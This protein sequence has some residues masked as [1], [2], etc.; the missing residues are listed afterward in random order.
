[1]LNQSSLA[2]V[3][4]FLILEP[5]PLVCF[6]LCPCAGAAFLSSPTRARHTQTL[7]APNTPPQHFV[8]LRQPSQLQQATWSLQ[9]L[10]IMMPSQLMRYYDG[11]L[12]LCLKYLQWSHE[13][14][15]KG[16]NPCILLH[17][18]HQQIALDFSCTACVAGTYK[19]TYGSQE[20][21]N[22]PSNSQS[23]STSDDI[24]DCRCNA[25]HGKLMAARPLLL[26]S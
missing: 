20:C 15:H 24:T 23:T 6:V 12:C 13:V 21:S 3:S 9:S 14:H 16:W 7:S 19:S 25:G 2:L 4:S 5:D 22:C 10:M 1:M 18:E 8:V 17:N 11:C 26:L